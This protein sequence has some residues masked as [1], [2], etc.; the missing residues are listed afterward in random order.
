MRHAPRRL[1]S[2]PNDV[3]DR[4]GL[5]QIEFA[6]QEAALGKF[7]GVCQPRSRCQREFQQPRPVSTVENLTR[8]LSDYDRAFGIV[9]G[10]LS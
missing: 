1:R 2:R 5:R 3:R 9:E 7:A 4:L 8:D 6:V 10:G